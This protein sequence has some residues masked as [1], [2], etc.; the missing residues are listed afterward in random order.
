MTA[1]IA[2]FVFLRRSAKNMAAKF[3]G[4]AKHIA[5]ISLSNSSAKL[6]HFYVDWVLSNAKA[7]KLHAFNTAVV[8]N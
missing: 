5:L 3:K 1:R 7:V 6:T 8:L 2:D 4:R